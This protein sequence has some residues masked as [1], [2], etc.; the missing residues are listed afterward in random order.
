MLNFLYISTWKLSVLS[1]ILIGLSYP[2]SPLGFLAWFGLIP[3]IHILLNS[4]ILNSMKWSF[5]TGVI[6][7]VITVYWFGLNSGAGLIPAIISMVAAILY[8]SIFW[9][10]FGFLCCSYHKMTGYG[11]SILPFLWVSM[12]YLRSFGPLSFPWIN[13]ALTQTFSLPLIQIA[14][15]TGSMGISFW[16]VVLNMIIYIAIISNSSKKQILSIGTLLLLVIFLLGFF[17]LS[18][19]Q[20]IN[21]DNKINVSIVQ[22]NI[23]PNLKWEQNFRDKIFNTMDSLHNEAITLDPD[24]ILWPEAA[25]PTYLRINYSKRRSILQKVKKSNI[26]LLTGTP[27]RIKR[28]DNEIEYYNAAMFIKPDGSTKMY[29]KMHLVPFAESIPFSNY[30]SFLKK[31]NF[32]QANFTA[33]SEYTLFNVD[34]VSFAN[35]ICY[36]SSIPKIAR[37]FANLGAKFITIETNDSWCGH[38]SGVYQHFQIAKMRAVENRIPIVR[39]ANTGISGLI[40]PTGKVNKKI[41]FNKQGILLASIPINNISSFYTKYGDWFALICTLISVITLCFGWFQKRS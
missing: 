8:L 35:L 24:F 3:L 25:L 19:I 12:E 39:S 1:G 27:D 28:E 40:L 5:I 16:I 17:R 15:V 21:A 37:K 18:F 36:E 31:L 41:H 26:P 20:N 7:N 32:G 30:F 33:G 23:D 34:S 22:P 29:Y 38:S 14:D 6:V 11:I 9:I 4:S 13:L 10:L 2:P